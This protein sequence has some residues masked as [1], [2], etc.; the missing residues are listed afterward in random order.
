MRDQL[1]VSI[2]IPP[3]VSEGPTAELKT[4]IIAEYID[5]GRHVPDVNPTSSNRSS[6]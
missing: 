3:R 4:G 5:Q 1:K 6:G 2:R